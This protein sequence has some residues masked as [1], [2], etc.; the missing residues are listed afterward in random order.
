MGCLLSLLKKR[1]KLIRLCSYSLKRP[2]TNSMS[3]LVKLLSGVG[4][5][6]VSPSCF[7]DSN[8][9]SINVF[10]SFW[11]RQLWT[12][13]TTHAQ[14]FNKFAGSRNWNQLIKFLNWNW[15]ILDVRIWP[16]VIH[17]CW[18]CSERSHVYQDLWYLQQI[19]SCSM[20]EIIFRP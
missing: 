14:C 5:G 18:I 4:C 1:T 19:K 3:V 9:F 2:L 11:L 6:T 12:F 8:N 15:N 17:L 10:N 13:V 20:P 16:N 7:A